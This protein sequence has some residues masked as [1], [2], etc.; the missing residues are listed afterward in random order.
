MDIEQHRTGGI[1]D[2]RNEFSS[3]SQFPDQPGIDRT[4]T[5]FPT[6]GTFPDP[7]HM[8]QNPTYLRGGEISIDHQSG[9]LLDQR[10]I[11]LCLQFFAIV[12]RTSVLPDDGVIDRK[13]GLPVPYYRRFTLVGNTDTSNMRIRHIRFSHS[14]LYSRRLCV[15]NL[16]RIM[17][18]PTGLRKILLECF[19]R[20]RD[21]IALMAEKDGSRRGRPLVDSQYVFISEIHIFRLIRLFIQYIMGGY[22][23]KVF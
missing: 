23:V 19:L 11:S 14:L 15:P 6:L 16:V 2:I 17:F 13:T 5:K 10:S 4:E 18:H 22:P 9:L 3:A 20:Q 12:C 1:C 7:L 8:I 21:N